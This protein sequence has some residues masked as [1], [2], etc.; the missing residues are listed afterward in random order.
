M[1][2]DIVPVQVVFCL[3]E[4]NQKKINSHRWLFNAFCPILDPTVVV[5]V[6][7]GT[8]LN[9]SAIY[10]LWKAFDR[11][12]NVAGAA[13]QIKTMKGKWGRKLLNPLVA[14]QNFEYKMSNILDKPLESVFGY[15]SVLPGALS[16]YRYRALKNHADG[17]GPLNSYSWAKRKR[18]GSTMCSLLTCT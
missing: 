14:S 15:I 13:G 7:V 11:D 16:A 2:K 12:S 1:S 17:T 9:D 10:H 3:K 5:L 4:E 18:A 8:K 6:D